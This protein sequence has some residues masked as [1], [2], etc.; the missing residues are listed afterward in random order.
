[1]ITRY[2]VE[3][4]RRRCN[5]W[6]IGNALT[7]IRSF[8][9]WLMHEGLLESDPTLAVEWPQHD[10]PIERALSKGELR[11]LFAAIAEPEGLEE[12][13]QFI[14]RRNRR[15]VYL[16]LYAG[17]RISETAALLWRDVYRESGAGRPAGQGRTPAR[18]S[19]LGVLVAPLVAAGPV[20]AAPG[21]PVA[22]DFSSAIYSVTRRARPAVVQIAGK[23]LPTHIGEPPSF[24]SSWW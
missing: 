17:L 18:A 12:A 24:S 21:T 4:S 3:M 6:T 2:R 5:G 23:N 8:C 14:W 22:T 16:M 10:D 15:V 19:A 9:R 1:M 13:Q 7:A 11:Q 20:V